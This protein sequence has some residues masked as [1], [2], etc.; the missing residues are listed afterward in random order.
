MLVYVR[1]CLLIL[2]LSL[3]I[4]VFV[5]SAIVLLSMNELHFGQVIEVCYASKQTENLLDHNGRP[6]SVSG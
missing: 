1:H 5:V 3:D 6:S 4:H 2:T